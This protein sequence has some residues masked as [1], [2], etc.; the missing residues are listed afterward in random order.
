MTRIRSFLIGAA[1][2]ALLSTGAQ[3][4]DLLVGGLD[5]VYDSPLF[6]FEGFYAGG[7]LGIGAFPGPGT[8]GTIGV[9][10]GANFGL[11]DAILAG[12]EFQGDA[13]W[14]GGGFVGFDALFLGKL[15]GYLT[16]ATLVYGTAGAGWAANDPS[17]AFGAGIEQSVTGQ[18]SVRGEAMAT[19]TWGG[20]VDGGKATASLL[21]HMN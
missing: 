8:V 20:W 14:N 13:L 15:G 9:V 3:A 5:P 11:T 12:V 18:L 4:A 21:W 1:A 6:H 10:A 19:G 16:D 17:Y 2:A 7:S